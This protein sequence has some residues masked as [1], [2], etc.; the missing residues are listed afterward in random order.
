VVMENV[1]RQSA[2]LQKL[3]QTDAS[4]AV[5]AGLRRE[6]QRLPLH[7]KR[8]WNVLNRITLLTNQLEKR[9]RSILPFE[10]KTSLPGKWAV[11][12]HLR[13]DPLTVLWQH[14]DRLERKMRE[15]RAQRREMLEY[16]FS[17]NKRLR[18]TLHHLLPFIG[19]N[20]HH[21]DIALSAGA[22]RNLPS[23]FV[24]TPRIHQKMI[25]AKDAFPINTTA[26]NLTELNEIAGQYGNPGMVL[27]LQISMSTEASALIALDRKL[28]AEREQTLRRN[29]TADIPS[30]WLVPL[31]EGAEEVENL[32]T[33]LDKLWDYAVQSRRLNQ[34]PAERLSEILCELFIAGSDLSQQVGQLKGA[35]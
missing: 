34:K 31:F 17:L 6:M 4:L 24:L 1:K 10:T 14:N 29:H 8:F 35:A 30:I 3:L 23:R 33:Y 7:N 11:R 21:K 20:L 26:Y 19:K 12:A 2:V 18:K 27:A 13:R 5:D 15:L 28:R 32:G 9:Y 25:L 22:F 16:Y